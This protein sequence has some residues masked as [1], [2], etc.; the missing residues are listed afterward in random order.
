MREAHPIRAA[1][2]LNKDAAIAA[3]FFIISVYANA[4]F[5]HLYSTTARIR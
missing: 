1:P 2:R 3:V 5:E 4:Q